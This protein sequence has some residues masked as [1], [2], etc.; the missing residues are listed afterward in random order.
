MISLICKAWHFSGCL[1]MNCCTT[2]KTQ[3]DIMESIIPICRLKY[4][5]II[6]VDL[7][8]HVGKFDENERR[9]HLQ[10]VADLVSIFNKHVVKLR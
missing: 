6:I 4:S 3:S 1:H 8:P 5:Q 9:S 2:D 7:I 10:F